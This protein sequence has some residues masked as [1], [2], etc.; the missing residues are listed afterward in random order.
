MKFSHNPNQLTCPYC[1]SKKYILALISGNTIGARIWS[2]SRRVCPMLPQVGPVHKCKNCGRFYFYEDGNPKEAVI[3]AG[4][5]EKARDEA[6]WNFFCGMNFTDLFCASKDLEATKTSEEQ[7]D[8]YL[9][10]CVFAY[11]DEK[12]KRADRD[13]EPIF[14]A[15]EWAFRMIAEKVIARFGEDKTI[16]AEL[17]RELGNFDKS[18]ELCHKLIAAGTDVEAVKQILA[19]AE[20]H[21]PEVFLLQVDR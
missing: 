2:D 11:N 8:R 20:Q 21:D 15:G 13:F 18:I 12:T 1:G 3:P 10:E 4:E 19:H 5:E 14:E 17:Y 16:T 7:W 6:C 9:L